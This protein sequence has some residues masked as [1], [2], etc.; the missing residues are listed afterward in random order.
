M[1]KSK[2]ILLLI[3]MGVV[4]LSSPLVVRADWSG[5]HM[6]LN[7]NRSYSD[8]EIITL[9]LGSKGVTSNQSISG[10]RYHILYDPE[11]LEPIS[12]ENDGVGSYHGWEKIYG[13]IIQ[14]GSKFKVREVDVF[15]NDKS[16][17]LT[18]TS[19]DIFVKL[20]YAKF[21]VKNTNQ[22]STTLT[23]KQTYEEDSANG[24][25]SGSTSSYKYIWLY[26]P[27]TNEHYKLPNEDPEYDYQE[28]C[29]DTITTYVNLY[30]K[31]YINN[32]IINNSVIK[33]YDKNVYNYN[34][35]YTTK[36]I[37]IEANTI[38]GY[39]ISG[40]LGKKTLNYGNNVFK[41]SVVSPTGDKKEYTLNVNYP[42]NRSNV[43]T[44]K[45]L[46]LSTG[47]IDFKPEI[48]A[49][50]VAVD[51]EVD[52]IKINSEL[53]NAKSSYIKDFG[54]R[55]VNLE[56]GNNEI[57][58]K[59][60]SEKG[61]TNV[62]TLNV[63]RKEPTNTCDIKE[64]KIDGYNLDFNTEKNNYTL[65]IDY[66]LSKLNINVSLFIEESNYKIIGYEKL[67]NGSKITIKVTDKNGKEND[68]YINIIKDMSIPA[69]EKNKKTIIVFSSIIGIGV[70]GITGLIIYLEKSKKVK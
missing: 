42:D 19:S 50:S 62:Y 47:T 15:T 70:L 40:D 59:I 37:N 57:L 9:D 1:V 33:N 26:N 7:E 39:T 52:K 28:P 20:G 51:Y 44:L 23:L 55:E 35:T 31:A 12:Y 56:V 46:T 64:L 65:E 3:F 6:A 11:V 58:I 14:N 5:C 48:N 66:K 60:Q 34:L 69:K 10:F 16:K 36:N 17:F 61:T 68:Y 8:G 22:S 24:F 27:Q 30:K 38:D 43:S 13:S 49:Y 32:I 45:S 29:F 53:S 2:K 21:K 18:S 67:T 4:L 63:T 54:N 25:R 41:I